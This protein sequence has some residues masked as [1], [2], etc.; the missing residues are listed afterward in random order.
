MAITIKHLDGPLA[1]Q[2]QRFGDDVQ[3]IVFG[4]SRE[5]AQVLYP[6]EYDVVGRKHFQ[7]RCTKAGDYSAELFGQRYVAID[8]IPADNGTPAKSG[9]VFRLG[10][11]DGPSFK[12]AVEAPAAAGIVTG[13]QSKMQTSAERDRQLRRRVIYAFAVLGVLVLGIG[14]YVAYLKSTLEYQIADAKTEERDS[15]KALFAPAVTEQLLRAVYLVVKDSAGVPEPEATAWA[16]APSKL[17]TNAHVTE[18]I[19]AARPGTFYLLGPTGERFEIRSVK[20]HPGYAAFKSVKATKGT[21]RGTAFTP[22]E[23]AS[24]Y[25]V[26]IIEVDTAK[27]LPATLELAAQDDLAKLAL[28]A[29][30][31]SAGF[32]AEGLVGAAGL[33]QAP[34]ATFEF[35]HI[36]AL[37]D[38]FMCRADDP[39]HRLLVQHSVPVTGGASGSPMI[40]ASGKVIAIVSGGNTVAL[41]DPT[42]AVGAKSR[43]P[44]AALVNFAQRAD[45]LRDFDAGRAPEALTDEQAYWE[46]AGKRFDDYFDVAVAEFQGDAKQ[47]YAVQAGEDSVLDSDGSLKP[48]ASAKSRVFVS[49]TYAF[50][51]APGFVYG[52][53][54]DAKDGVPIGISIKQNGAFV[55]EAKDPRKS[56]EPELAPTAW[57]TVTEKANLDVVVWGQISQPAGYVLHVYRWKIPGAGAQSSDASPAP[58]ASLP[59]EQDR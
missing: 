29:P 44:N 28:G 56:F 58:A 11:A 22:L 4:R 57:V 43:M 37:K 23:L 45:L 2:E 14:G 59:P 35:G 5:E 27:P 49:R 20:S 24:A 46:E 50:Q 17:A 12:V 31:A 53:I 33:A 54:A 16:F 55:R 9:S 3:E 8:G 42:A 26:G 7:L 21:A 19:K 41:N 25:D 39:K 6:P 48:P 30:V 38:V 51:A 13:K 40:D 52:F 34:V 15:A 47:R 18:A 36:S 32:P 10:R 1:G